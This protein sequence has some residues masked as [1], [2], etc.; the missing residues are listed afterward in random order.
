MPSA[1]VF[2][3]FEFP[4]NLQLSPL[5]NGNIN[6]T[7][8]GTSAEGEKVVLQR[9]N[10]TVFPYPERIMHNYRV[11]LSHLR[12]KDLKLH[13][14]NLF[15]G[16]DGQGYLFDEEGHCWRAVEYLANTMAIERAETPAQ[17]RQ[18]GSAVGTFLSGLA[19]LNPDEVQD[20]L[21]GFHDSLSRYQHFLSAVQHNLAA[22]LSEVQAEVEFV[23]REAKVFE[24]I[25]QL[26]LPLRVVHNDPKIANVLF[27]QH[28]GEAV[29]L[30][31]WDTIQAGSFLSDFGDMVR[32]MTPSFS[33]DEPDTSK[34]HLEMPLFK[35]LV[36]GFVPTIQAALTPVERDN[37]LQGAFWIILEQMMRFLGDYL[38][39]DQY[40]KVRYP[41][42]NL[43][44]ARN[45]MALYQSIQAQESDLQRILTQYLSLGAH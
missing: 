41:E 29:A 45:Q 26:G 36:Q 28:S 13:L 15:P 14:P 43:V 1:T 19:D 16:I 40:Y 22:R 35:G 8:L 5:G 32:S 10:S 11:V 6:D 17:A 21:P 38:N 7:W 34:V 27:D 44:R 18:A 31:D 30:I 23:K 39:G 25:H 42:H 33:E 24:K 20:A 9:I 2:S 4:E 12:S 3:Y 37:L